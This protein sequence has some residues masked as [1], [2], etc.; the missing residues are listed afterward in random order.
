MAAKASYPSSAH[1]NARL[2]SFTA[3]IP[4]SG[5]TA[6]SASATSCSGGDEG[7]ARSSIMQQ[8]ESVAFEADKRVFR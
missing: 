6:S 4:R 3:G 1:D 5:I 2:S 8:P 7:D